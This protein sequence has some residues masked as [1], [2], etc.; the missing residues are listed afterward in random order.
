MIIIETR[1][2]AG[3][4]WPRPRT[5]VSYVFGQQIRRYMFLQEEAKHQRLARPYRSKSR[6]L[7]RV[8]WV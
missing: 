8:T 6:D 4:S 1:Y 2:T 5:R 7:V 3:F